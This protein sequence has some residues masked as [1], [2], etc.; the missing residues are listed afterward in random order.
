MNSVD[1]AKQQHLIESI[2]H[3]LPLL[4]KKIDFRYQHTNVNDYKFDLDCVI[5]GFDMHISSEY[6]MSLT[7][8]GIKLYL[9]E[10]QQH[11]LKLILTRIRKSK[12]YPYDRVFYTKEK[13]EITDF[14]SLYDKI[15]LK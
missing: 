5:N 12:K 4:G 3:D 11:R 9:N 1:K 6:T 13:N 7:V 14:R 15:T 2:L 10:E 8:S